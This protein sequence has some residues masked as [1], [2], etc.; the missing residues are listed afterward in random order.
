[1]NENTVSVANRTW[2]LPIFVDHTNKYKVGVALYL[3]AIV[4]YLSSNHIHIFEPQQLPMSWVDQ[5]V[6]FI[7]WTV[8]IYI[9]EYFLFGSV[10]ILTRNSANL[11]RYV[12]SFFFLQATSV[13]IFWVW[14][15][16]FPRGDFPLGEG[17]DPLT[18]WMFDSLRSM[19]SPANCAP[20]LHVSC[21]YLSAFNFLNEQKKK[22][23]FFFIWAT[24]VAAATL[25]T[26]QHYLIDVVLGFI[27][28]VAFYWIFQKVV[29]YHQPNR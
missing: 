10:F 25:T 16:T 3:F 15:T 5:A 12:Y 14:P 24:A 6:P 28:A 11:S 26:K 7:P 19:D 22:F 2:S 17:V 1:M 13:L 20:S 23:P 8:W 29:Q 21:C 4:T 18:Y 9:S 27:M